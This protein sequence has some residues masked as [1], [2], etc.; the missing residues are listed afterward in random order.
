[1]EDKLSLATV[2]PEDIVPMSL[3][4]NSTKKQASDHQKQISPET[5]T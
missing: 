1:M 3:L 5:L 2:N 4:Q